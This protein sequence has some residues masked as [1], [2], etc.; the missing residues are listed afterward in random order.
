MKFSQL[1]FTKGAEWW[2]AAESG[3]SQC[4]LWTT[5]AVIIKEPTEGGR[6]AM[7]GGLGLLS[8]QVGDWL[9]ATNQ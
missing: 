8:Y 1:T 7:D 6:K 5:T 3:P 2:T 9:L 4:P